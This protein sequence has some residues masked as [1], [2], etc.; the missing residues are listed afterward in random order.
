MQPDPPRLPQ[1]VTVHESTVQ[2]VATGEHRPPQRRRRKR[3]PP[4][5]SVSAEMTYVQVRPDVWA[6]A[7]RLAQHPSHIQVLG[8]EEVIVWN[9]PPP[10]PGSTPDE[11]R[12]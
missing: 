9:H 4:S 12:G 6:E 7:R 5:G 2:K 1:T 8:S 3:G 11:G 10:W